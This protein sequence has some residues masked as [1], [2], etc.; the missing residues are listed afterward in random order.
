MR[1]TWFFGAATALAASMTAASAGHWQDRYGGYPV[2]ADCP[3]A[4][5]APLPPA[6]VYE[7]PVYAPSGP[8]YAVP[9]QPYY[10]VDQGPSYPAP[11]VSYVTPTVIYDIPRTYP[12]VSYGNYGRY[13]VYGHRSRAVYRYGAQHRV[14]HRRHYGYHETHTARAA[15]PRVIYGPRFAHRGHG[16]HHGMQHGMHG[17][18]HG[19]HHRHGMGLSRPTFAPRHRHLDGGP[20]THIQVRTHTRVR[21]GPPPRRPLHPHYPR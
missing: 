15:P 13:P 18:R 19:V 16:M 21:F 10:L 9:E 7:A 3:C 12:Y 11:V 17:G 6:V 1:M 5:A 20:R 4:V 2:Q 8:V 14:I